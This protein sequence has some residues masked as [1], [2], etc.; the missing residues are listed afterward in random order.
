M[1]PHRIVHA[2]RS[3]GFAGVERHVA[4]LARAQADRGD[5]VTVIGGDRTRMALA[6]K[7]TSVQ[8]LPGE[9][10]L[11][12]VKAI[13]RVAGE[14]DL[15]HAHM[16]AAEFA[17]SL[18]AFRPSRTLPIVATRHFAAPRGQG[19]F[20]RLIAGFIARR[21]SAQISISRF[22]ADRIEGS[23]EIVYPGVEPQQVPEVPREP[24]ALIVQRLEPE[25]RTDIAVE[26]FARSGLADQG[27]RLRIAGDGSLRRDL[28]QQAAEIGIAGA[29]D[30]LGMRTD[31]WELMA[32]ASMMLAPCPVEGLG[33]GVLEAM[34]AGLPVIAS[35]VGGH[36]E[37]LSDDAHQYCFA[38]NDAEA[39]A[40]A[41]KQLAGDP[42]L[43][44]DLAERGM[45]RQRDHFT[46]G[47]QAAGTAAV[48]TAVLAARRS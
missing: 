11:R 12:V 26:A 18:A 34:G 27:W 43:R 44:Q 15:V 20:G 14:A 17:A 42:V 30:F 31:V 19:H 1:R 32:Q 21:I 2:I 45:Q 7:D 41:V 22:V 35:Q 29:V 13:S 24:V 4:V 48:Y 47:V 28:E 5:M 36:L 40:V 16:T 3:D 25:K 9:T 33:L 46:P 10:V 6:L 37:T 38:D 23:S 8:F 39:A